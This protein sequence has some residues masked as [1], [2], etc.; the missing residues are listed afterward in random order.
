MHGVAALAVDISAHSVSIC[1]PM[2][3]RSPEMLLACRQAYLIRNQEAHPPY[4]TSAIAELAA[5]AAIA[6]HHNHTVQPPPAG[7]G[8]P[9]PIGIARKLM[10]SARANDRFQCSPILMEQK[11]RAKSNVTR[12]VLYFLST[13]HCCTCCSQ[14]PAQN[15]EESIDK[16]ALSLFGRAVAVWSSM[17]PNLAPQMEL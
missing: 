11:V 2:R 17:A 3:R 8:G 4:V 6:P 13:V 7:E 10:P 5:C 15:V 12:P 14:S 16:V 1:S 9:R